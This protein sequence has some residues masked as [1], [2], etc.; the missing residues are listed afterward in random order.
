M[1]VPRP[2]DYPQGASWN[3][4]CEVSKDWRTMK[5]HEFLDKSDT[6]Y[7]DYVSVHIKVHGETSWTMQLKNYFQE[8]QGRGEDSFPFYF[9]SR[10]A[11]GDLTVGKQNGP[12]GKQILRIDG[13]HSAP[14]EH[15]VNYGTCMV[16]G[17]GI[18]L[19]PCA[20]ILTALTRYR[21]KKGF[22]PEIL[23]FYW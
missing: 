11:R 7:F 17:A 3:R 16:I 2:K 18:G 1:E 10:D 6:G 9:Y 14:S 15:Y 13:P 22:S 12:D 19:T 21:W 23:H 20:S 8:M 4:Y 5:M